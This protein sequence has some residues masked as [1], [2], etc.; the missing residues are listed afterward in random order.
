MMREFMTIWEEI[1]RMRKCYADKAEEFENEG[2]DAGF[3]RSYVGAYDALLTFMRGDPRFGNEKGPVPDPDCGLMV[4]L[5]TGRYAMWFENT[6]Q[7]ARFLDEAD[8]Y[9]IEWRS[10]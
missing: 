7:K 5:A 6:E 1:T 8:P 3:L 9:I 2:R 10:L 4:K